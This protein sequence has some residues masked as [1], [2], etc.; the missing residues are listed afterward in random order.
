[1]PGTPG[2]RGRITTSTYGVPG[3]FTT[4]EDLDCSFL[5]LPA[6]EPG[7]KIDLSTIDLEDIDW[8]A[9]D[10]VHELRGSVK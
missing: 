1:M 5:L 8:E 4:L 3:T 9:F 10:A 2:G 7:R 6:I